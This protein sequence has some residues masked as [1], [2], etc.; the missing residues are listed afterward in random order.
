MSAGSVLAVV[1]ALAGWGRPMP[2]DE[3]QGL[4]EQRFEVL[5]RKGLVASGVRE[6]FREGVR[7]LRRRAEEKQEGGKMYKM[8]R[9]RLRSKMEYRESKE[10]Q[11]QERKEKE[12]EQQQ[13]QQQ[14]FKQRQQKSKKEETNQVHDLHRSSEH[15]E[16]KQN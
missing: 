2:S 6:R 16:G 5:D 8:M 11:Q 10:E 7:R 12:G 9:K 14:E 15:Q 13:Q 4:M 3:L 1:E